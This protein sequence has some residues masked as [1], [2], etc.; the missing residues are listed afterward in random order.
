MADSKLSSL[1]YPVNPIPGPDFSVPTKDCIPEDLPTG[2][3]VRVLDNGKIYQ[4]LDMGG[5]KYCWNEQIEGD[6]V[7]KQ[8]E[9]L[10]MESHRMMIFLDMSDK[11]GTG[12]I[13][14]MDKTSLNREQQKQLHA[15]GFA[16]AKDYQ[17]P[18]N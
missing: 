10:A 6:W 18:R 14:V 2:S 3:V 5:G 4:R 13:Q 7:T 1:E 15:T 9:G 12:N 16:Y 11:Q 8:Q 17:S